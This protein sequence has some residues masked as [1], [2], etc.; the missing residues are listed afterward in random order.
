MLSTTELS[1]S[2]SL[3]MFLVPLLFVVAIC[4]QVAGPG[5]GVLHG[6]I[7]ANEGSSDFT[8]EGTEA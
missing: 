7:T 8:T 3:K 5:P 1:I 2:P 4:R 6:G